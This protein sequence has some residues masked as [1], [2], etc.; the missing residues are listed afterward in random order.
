MQLLVKIRHWKVAMA[1]S[2]QKGSGRGEAKFETD[3]TVLCTRWLNGQSESRLFVFPE[4]SSWE[5]RWCRFRSEG[6][7]NAALTRIILRKLQA[8][9]NV[10]C[11]LG[12]GVG[13]CIIYAAICAKQ[14]SHMQRPT[15]SCSLWKIPHNITNKLDNENV[16][17]FFKFNAALSTTVTNTINVVNCCTILKFTIYHGRKSC[18]RGSCLPIWMSGPAGICNSDFQLAVLLYH[19]PSWPTS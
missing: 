14:A 6:S 1:V 11:D 4:C 8:G 7:V 12:A 3:C 17:A 16:S 19:L 13:R 9:K 5:S 15:R 10:V 2:M 18:L